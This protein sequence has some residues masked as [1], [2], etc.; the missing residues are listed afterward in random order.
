MITPDPKQWDSV[1]D[2]SILPEPSTCL[3]AAPSLQAAQECCLAIRRIP[4]LPGNDTSTMPYCILVW[5]GVPEVPGANRVCKR[6][7]R[8]RSKG[9]GL[10]YMVALGREL[11]ATGMSLAALFCGFG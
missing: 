8:K 5:P 11:E 3:T 10:R 2:L 1:I 6:A 7:A 4:E 9:Q